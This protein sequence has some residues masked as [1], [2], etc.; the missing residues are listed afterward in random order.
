MAKIDRILVVGGGVAG[1][2]AAAA[3]SRQHL[4]VELVERRDTWWAPGAGFLVHANGM[5][6]LTPLGL[7][8]GVEKAG[9]VVRRWHFCDQ[10]GNLLSE[11]DLEALWDG[12]GPCIGIER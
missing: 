4:P 7:G 8:S 12:A 11:T 3:L 5:R 10:Q 1:L 6:M 2:T 9:A